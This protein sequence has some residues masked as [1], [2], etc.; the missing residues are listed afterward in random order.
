VLGVG[1][2]ARSMF[3][4]FRQGCARCVLPCH[5]PVQKARF[6]RGALTI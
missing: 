2:A 4:F 6:T 1:S 3:L 5:T